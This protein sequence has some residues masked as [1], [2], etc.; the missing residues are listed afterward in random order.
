MCVCAGVRACE[1]YFG[2]PMLLASV[3]ARVMAA[4]SGGG[5]N[6]GVMFTSADGMLAENVHIR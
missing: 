5:T 1:R 3:G 4:S 6:G 2:R